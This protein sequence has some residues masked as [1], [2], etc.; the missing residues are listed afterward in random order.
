MKTRKLVR[1]DWAIKTVL[2]NKAN[3]SIL[4]GFLSELLNTDVKIKELLESESNKEN[5]E[6]KSSR[7]DVFAQLAG[8]EKV[9]IEVQCQR[10][11][12]FLSRILYGVSKVVVEHLK[13]GDLYGAIPRVISVNI[14]YFDLGHGKDYIY[15]G[16]TTFKGI[17]KQDVLV[18][19]KEEKEHY[20]D[21]IDAIE[22]V[23]PEYYVLK[24]Q[25]F[26]LKIRNTLD[27][28]MY[29]LRESEV[30]PEFKAK[31][32]QTAAKTLDLLQLSDIERRRYERHIHDA[33]VE[34]SVS[35]T[36]YS[37]GKAEGLA[38][39]LAK[40]EAKKEAEMI[41]AMHAEGVSISQI[42]K[43]ARVSQNQVQTIIATCSE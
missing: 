37:E 33:R 3:F 9:I 43:C 39:G 42:A 35:Q 6:D 2:R 25:Q 27:E 36:Y 29:A 40:G 18:L 34:L 22:N 12:D 41:L 21:H 30:K 8:G 7:F 14:V 17:H 16:T 4:E 11:W 32:I 26:D 23:F 28:W 19:G 13:K 20:P 31:G 1:F 24:V 15:H 5:G 10:E 38:E